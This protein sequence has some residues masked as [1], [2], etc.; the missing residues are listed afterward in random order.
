[1]KIGWVIVPFLAYWMSLL[2]SRI[3]NLVVPRR[4]CETRRLTRPGEGG[5][6]AWCPQGSGQTVQELEQQP[7]FLFIEKR[8]EVGAKATT[9]AAHLLRERATGGG[10]FNTSGAAVARVPGARDQ[11]FGFQ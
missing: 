1:M 8:D 4:V 2:S 11:P 6:A 3:S 9:A 5:R 7:K 10:E